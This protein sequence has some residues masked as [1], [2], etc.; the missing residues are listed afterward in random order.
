MGT[1]DE[2]GSYGRFCLL[3]G[4]FEGE[5]K[6]FL[7]VLARSAVTA[8]TDPHGFSRPYSAK[9]AAGKLP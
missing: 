9:E 2:N 8:V 6:Y 7:K 5:G 3:L 1:R 4:V